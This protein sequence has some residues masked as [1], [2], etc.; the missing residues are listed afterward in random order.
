[1]S[2]LLKLSIFLMI[3]AYA[4]VLALNMPKCQQLSGKS[5]SAITPDFHAKKDRNPFRRNINSPLKSS[6]SSSIELPIKVSLDRA[7]IPGIVMPPK[8]MQKLDIGRPLWGIFIA[9]ILL[10][11]PI[12][13]ET[14]GVYY[15]VG[16]FA[17][18]IIGVIKSALSC[19]VASILQMA[20]IIGDLVTFPDS[21]I[22]RLL[23]GDERS[24]FTIDTWTRCK[25]SDIESIDS[26]F[27]K[28]TFEFPGHTDVN[29][30]LDIGQQ[31][32]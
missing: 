7:I 15:F 32:V 6:F 19:S 25:L 18:N 14:A 13:K 23:H 28:Y 11:V 29:I 9:L 17:E 27:N 5:R 24:H 22:K 8:T 4:T 10:S 1:M 16:E 26:D 30:D 2:R 3:G 12:I 20:A 31:V 21:L